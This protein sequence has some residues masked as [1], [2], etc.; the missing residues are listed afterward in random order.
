M[1]LVTPGNRSSRGNLDSEKKIL[2]SL[3]VSSPISV[4][5]TEGIKSE[6]SGFENMMNSTLLPVSCES[7]VCPDIEMSTR[8]ACACVTLGVKQ[9]TALHPTE[10][11]SEQLLN[12]P[13]IFFLSAFGLEI[14]KTQLSSAVDPSFDNVADSTKFLPS[15]MIGVPPNETPVDGDT[16]S[17]VPGGTYWK[18][19]PLLV[20]VCPSR[21]TS[22]VTS[23]GESTAS[24]SEGD[25]QTIFSADSHISSVVISVPN[26]HAAGELI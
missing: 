20:Y 2:T 8:I 18:R 5:P 4:V 15:I 7:S 17:T 13:G 9:L 3:L 23:V 26:L 16:R 19:Y 21:A 11:E 25:T 10:L 14:I 6:I 22:T 12:V 24:S 1:L